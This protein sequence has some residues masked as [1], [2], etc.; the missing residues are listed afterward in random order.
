M[1]QYNLFKQPILCACFLLVC[2]I[3]VSGCAS[4][5]SQSVYSVEVDTNPSGLEISITDSRTKTE[6]FSGTTPANLTLEASSGFFQPSKYLV[7]C[8]AEG[9]KDIVFPIKA[10]LDGWFILSLGTIAGIVIDAAT[11]SMYKFDEKYEV[12][13]SKSTSSINKREFKIY[14]LEDVP[15]NARKHLVKIN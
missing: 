7:R 1:K 5:M 14:A 2:V 12:N 10:K 6:V 8:K 11:G 13:A 4:I 9:Y 15:Y 3:F